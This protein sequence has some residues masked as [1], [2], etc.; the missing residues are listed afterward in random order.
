[1]FPW[2]AEAVE[3]LLALDRFDEAV[4]VADQVADQAA[5]IDIPT[6]GAHAARCRGLVLAHAGDLK[7]AEVQL[8]GAFGVEDAF[9]VRMEAARSLLALGIVRRRLRQKALAREDLARARDMFRGCGAAAWEARAARE[10]ERATATPAGA[11]LSEGER[12]VAALAAAGV[13]NR[14]IAGRLFLSEKTVEAVLTRVYR[15]LAV[16][17]RTELAHHP[18]LAGMSTAPQGGA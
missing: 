3:A 5:H 8:A 4:A 6:A 15:K 16:R 11:E 9:G 17:S 10:L 13:T 12:S 18:D 1:V 7:G 14:E 2:F